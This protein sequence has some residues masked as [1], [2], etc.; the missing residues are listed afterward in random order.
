[1]SSRERREI[2]EHVMKVSA[3]EEQVASLEREVAKLREEFHKM[4]VWHSKELTAAMD[5]NVKLR[6]LVKHLRECTRHNI[7]AMCKYEDDV[8]NFD[9]RMS[10][11]GIEVE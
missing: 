6:E 8:C 3:M 5:D 4:D 11:L 1:M 9:Y 7:C 2:R 10:E